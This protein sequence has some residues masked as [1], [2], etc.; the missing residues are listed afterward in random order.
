MLGFNNYF[1]NEIWQFFRIVFF[2]APHSV[3][4]Y[5]TTPCRYVYSVCTIYDLNQWNANETAK[6]QTILMKFKY[7]N[8]VFPFPKIENYEFDILC[9]RILIMTLYDFASFQVN[10]IVTKLLTVA[11]GENK[12]KYLLWECEAQGMFIFGLFFWNGMNY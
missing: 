5:S 6:G 3:L 2:C 7:A 11:W 10:Y 1:P 9:D 8:C 12:I 4:G